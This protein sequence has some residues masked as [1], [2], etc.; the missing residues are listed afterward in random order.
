MTP[1]QSARIDDLLRRIQAVVV[2]LCVLGAISFLA[3]VASQRD[4]TRQVLDRV[5]DL[6]RQV[7]EIEGENRRAAR[8]QAELH[9]SQ[10]EVRESLKRLESFVDAIKERAQKAEEARKKQGAQK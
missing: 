7:Q 6:S 9:E 3:V 1:E 5:S 4:A 2:V 10:G 8:D